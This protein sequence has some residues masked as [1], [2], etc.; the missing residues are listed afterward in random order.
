MSMINEYCFIEERESN[1]I[2]CHLSRC[3]NVIPSENYLPAILSMWVA[4]LIL[5]AGFVVFEWKN[6]FLLMDARLSRIKPSSHFKLLIQTESVW[7]VTFTFYCKHSLIEIDW[8][9][10]RSEC[11]H[12]RQLLE[13]NCTIFLCSLDD[14]NIWKSMINAEVPVWRKNIILLG[15]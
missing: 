8:P 10:S 7:K 4:A 14:G 9:E 5:N 12:V 15:Y 6:H 2:W 13:H 3:N 1:V 11:A